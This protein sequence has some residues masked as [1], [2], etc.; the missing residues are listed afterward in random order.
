M[1]KEIKKKEG[2]VKSLT[3]LLLLLLYTP[4]AS[5]K[6]GESIDGITKLGKLLFLLWKEGSFEKYLKDISFEA[7]KFGPFSLEM[8]DEIE[9][10]FNLGLVK[11]TEKRATSSA[12]SYDRIELVDNDALFDDTDVK[13]S[14]SKIKETFEL[15][16]QGM[17]AAKKIATKL[18]ENELKIIRNI[19]TIYNSMPLFQLLR[20][21]YTKY[22][23]YTVE[24]D[25]R[26]AVL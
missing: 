22:P 21:V 1:Q 26:E 10:L 19:K 12:E 25:I 18:S 13:V 9:F 20:Y 6:E 11:K 2:N 14:D 7:Y 3:E 24:S 16:E 17:K 15:T 5:G 4:G 23:S 8:Y